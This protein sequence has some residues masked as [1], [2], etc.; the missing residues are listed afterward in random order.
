MHTAVST[1]QTSSS[2]LCMRTWFHAYYMIAIRASF[3]A[4]CVKAAPRRGKAEFFHGPPLIIFQ[5]LSHLRESHGTHDLACRRLI[6]L[7]WTIPCL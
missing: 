5:V 7:P 3:Y 2:L 6:L 4:Y 1:L